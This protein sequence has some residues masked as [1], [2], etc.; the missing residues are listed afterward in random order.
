MST[1]VQCIIYHFCE[2]WCTEKYWF[3]LSPQYRDPHVWQDW[4]T[5]I[6]LT[7]FWWSFSVTILWP[8]ALWYRYTAPEIRHHSGHFAVELLLSLLWFSASWKFPP[9]PSDKPQP[10]PGVGTTDG[11]LFIL[12]LL[13]KNPWKQWRVLS[14]SLP[15]PI[16]RLEFPKS[17]SLS[18][19]KALLIKNL[20]FI[21]H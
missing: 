15:R 3:L 18:A 14:S 5:G 13:W 20:E 19:A 11:E 10:H 17:H 21:V 9:K 8:I 2:C 7:E 4:K 12:W 6:L 16:P 1:S